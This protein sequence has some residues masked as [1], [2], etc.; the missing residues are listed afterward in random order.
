MASIN[1]DYYYKGNPT[2]EKYYQVTSVKQII[3]N[4]AFKGFIKV[5]INSKYFIEDCF[6]AQHYFIY[7]NKELYINASNISVKRGFTVLPPFA[8]YRENLWNILRD[9]DDN[10]KVIN[11]ITELISNLPGL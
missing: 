3:N 7:S 10:P 11:Y 6:R 5:E 9:I 4:D 8:G 2:T 1:Y